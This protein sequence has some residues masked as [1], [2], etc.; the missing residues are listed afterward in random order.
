MNEGL[1]IRLKN[2]D[3]TLTN[4]N[5]HYNNIGADGAKAIVDALKINRSLTNLDFV[6]Q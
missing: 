1:L 3:P 2:N 4:L 6:L 5:L